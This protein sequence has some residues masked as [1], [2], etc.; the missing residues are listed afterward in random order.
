MPCSADVPR[1][2]RRTKLTGRSLLRR[3]T[4]TF[5][6]GLIPAVPLLLSTI[7]CLSFLRLVRTGVI[8]IWI[9]RLPQAKMGSA[10][11]QNEEKERT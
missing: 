7:L 11:A 5:P 6:T 3:S 10:L 9:L 1:K 2:S 8:D 4:V